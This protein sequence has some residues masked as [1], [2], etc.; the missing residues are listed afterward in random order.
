[1]GMRTVDQN[2]RVSG[3]HTTRTCGNTQCF[4]GIFPQEGRDKYPHPGPVLFLLW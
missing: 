2:I 3:D 1:M 4:N